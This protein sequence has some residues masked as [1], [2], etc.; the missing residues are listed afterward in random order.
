M[1]RWD[2]SHAQKFLSS[3]RV[4]S[5]PLHRWRKT[6]VTTSPAICVRRSSP[7]ATIIPILISTSTPVSSSRRIA[8]IAPPIFVSPSALPAIFSVSIP[9]V[10]P[11]PITALL[12]AIISVSMLVSRPVFLF[13]RSTPLISLHR[14]PP[15]LVLVSFF[16]PYFPLC[17]GQSTLLFSQSNS[18]SATRLAKSQVWMIDARLLALLLL[19]LQS[20]NL[21]GSRSLDF[22]CIR[23]SPS[24][25][26]PVGLLL[27]CEP[28]SSIQS[29]VF[30]FFQRPDLFSLRYGGR[31]ARRLVFT[32]IPMDIFVILPSSSWSLN[33]VPN[34]ILYRA[35]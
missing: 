24:P 21:F 31:I 19:F 30:R 17:A 20:L 26:F 18:S 12:P 29:L 25:A 32:R 34:V 33:G 1:S 5:F 28:Q 23:T 6:P 3:G 4:S 35:L 11:S 9:L 8:R 14:S 15:F 13:I 16:S 7:L 27:R 2:A 22:D 10:S